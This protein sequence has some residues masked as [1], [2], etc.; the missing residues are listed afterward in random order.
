MT[1]IK[2]RTRR[3]FAALLG[4]L[5]ALSLL[6][7]TAFAKDG[8]ATIVVTLPTGEAMKDVDLSGITVTP[9]LVLDQVNDE[10]TDVSKKQYEVTEGFKPFFDHV[11]KQAPDEG[12]T[13]GLTAF[14]DG[15]G[16]VY[17]TY[18]ETDK[19]LMASKTKPE[20]DTKYI[21]LTNAKALD[22]T[23]PEAELLSRITAADDLTTLYSWIEKYIKAKV[24]EGTLSPAKQESGVDQNGTT[25]TI[26]GL[27]EGYYA[28]L[29]ANTPSAVSVTQGIMVATTGATPVEIE[30]KSETI[31][32]VKQVKNPDH[33]G[34][35][36]SDTTPLQETTADVGDELTY[37][38][39]TKVPTLANTENLTIFKME[40]TMQNQQ[41][42]G[43]M[44]LTL[45]KDGENTVSFT[46]AVPT[47]VPGTVN[48]TGT[49][50][51]IATL[52]VGAYAQNTETQIN[53]QSFTV[54][55]MA[56]DLTDAITKY[57][58]YTVTL[59]YNA[60][61]TADAVKVNENDVKLYVNNNDKPL[62]D[63]T[64]VYTYGVEVQKTF[65]DGST[66]KYSEVT[67]SLY[68][69]V[70]GSKG[71]DALHFVEMST[72][73]SGSYRKPV[74]SSET[75]DTVLKLDGSGKLTITGLDV[76][77]Y[78]LVENE[79]AD[80]YTK[81]EDIQIVLTADT[82]NKEQLDDTLTTAKIGGNGKNL[83]NVDNSTGSISLARFDVLNQKGFELPETGG[84]GT[85]MFTIGGIL[86][87]A[88]AGV[89]FVL[90]R[91]KDGS[92]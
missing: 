2:R 53:E 27:N 47:S 60:M 86:L 29:F 83:A 31:P 82:T 89:L 54:D 90:S 3:L 75:G 25:M 26:N 49:T 63:K 7:T 37:H 6:S 84:A 62:E 34:E 14:F 80:G 8:E 87:V 35:D 50:G 70:N 51:T 9:Y 15:T 32:L 33:T 10:E 44:T 48:F 56:Q 13:S 65:S 57:Q 39:T 66:D 59:T 43:S 79:T 1:E 68:P 64:K 88:A 18:N 21:A 41:L 30:L 12:F 73:V 42:T 69:D 78:W 92:K 19:K 11:D 55:F 4:L 76:G 28:L 46:A 67:F 5:M 72:G 22:Q 77:T 16:T 71:D 52:D 24:E 58:G 45:T 36:F 81:S 91:K 40:D 85:W 17:L 23:Y 20:D 38:I 74:G 61:V